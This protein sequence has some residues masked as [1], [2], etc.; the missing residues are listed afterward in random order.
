[1]YMGFSITLFEYIK[2]KYYYEN[3]HFGSN[4]KVVPK[5]KYF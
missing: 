5:C 2:A 3:A 4:K 1:M